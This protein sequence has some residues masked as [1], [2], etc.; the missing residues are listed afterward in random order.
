MAQ[1]QSFTRRRSLLNF[2]S[3]G[4]SGTASAPDLLKPHLTV[5]Q[6][7]HRKSK[8]KNGNTYCNN[9]IIC[10]LVNQFIL[11]NFL[12]IPA[13]WAGYL[14]QQVS[15]CLVSS[16]FVHSR[17]RLMGLMAGL[18]TVSFRLGIHKNSSATSGFS[19]FFGQRTSKT[20]RTKS[21]YEVEHQTGIQLRERS[22][23][24]TFIIHVQNACRFFPIL[25]CTLF[26]PSPSTS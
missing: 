25:F 19:G 17:N 23:I 5:Q 15:S 2:R 24:E 13:S 16:C 14:A 21:N 20:R 1:T 22:S 8:K 12:G 10:C 18:L 4:I 11:I 7:N 9:S 6:N 26:S 3:S